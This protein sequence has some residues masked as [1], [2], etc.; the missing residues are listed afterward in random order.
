MTE[1]A[2]NR[3][4]Q[5]G[6]AARQLIGFRLGPE[7]FGIDISRIHEIIKP[8]PLTVVPDMPPGYSGV[9]RLRE[10][11]IVIADLHQRFAF[12]RTDPGKNTRIIVLAGTG[13]RIGVLVD[14]VS[15]VLRLTP[16]MVD[17]S[18]AFSDG[19]SVDYIEAIGK[20][21]TDLITI[22]DVDALFPDTAASHLEQAVAGHL[23]GEPAAP[24]ICMTVVGED[25]T[26]PLGS[27][28][29]I[30]DKLYRDVGELARYINVWHRSFTED[31]WRNIEVKARDLPTA[32]DI[33]QAV[34]EDTETATMKVMANA[35]ETLGGIGNLEALLEQVEKAVP[36][37]AKAR[38]TISEL[39]ERMRGEL[40]SMHQVQDDTM[41]ALSFQDLT[42]QKIRQVIGL[43][44]DVEERI[45]ELVVEYGVNSAN[46]AAELVE[47]KLQDLK[48]TKEDPGLHQD[49]VDDLL[50]EFGF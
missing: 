38:A 35:E 44:M 25:V 11:V 17:P 28:A 24:E 43:M 5:K 34:T 7:H 33:L 47:R 21:G 48:E 32:N 6:T 15:E 26:E 29:E 27:K 12:P 16:A 4:G 10:Q 1:S 41:I 19:V 42:G 40:A 22:L 36:A 13:Q 20:L 2:A 49:R 46:E 9:I 37:S 3:E 23:A 14:A 18:P 8:L 39:A 45:V 50:A 31:L 30:S